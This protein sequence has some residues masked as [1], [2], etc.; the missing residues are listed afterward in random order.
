MI[1]DSPTALYNSILPRADTDVGNVT[2]TI[3]SN[4][5]P[6]PATNSTPLSRGQSVRPLPPRIYDHQTR[7]T[8]FGELVFSVSSGTQSMAPMSTKAFEVGQILDF[9]EPEPLETI[10]VLNV[11]DTVDL[12]QNT[13]VLDFAAAGLTTDEASELQTSAA[14]Q[15]ATKINE[16]N[17]IKTQISDNN[18]A[19]QDNQRLLNEIQKLI[20]ASTVVFGSDTTIP[21]K[22]VVRQ[23]ELQL[24]R[25]NLIN[26]T[27]VLTTEAQT[28]YAE[29]LELKE[30][31]R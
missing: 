23:Q 31:V 14:E 11:P 2:F 30:V 7:R 25:T 1:I 19:I 15:I 17:A 24:E 3:S 4:D 28:K 26:G 9:D 16:L 18:T 22:L 21:D 8:T 5:P 12:Q 29:I 10:A 6:R 27:N 20:N 13:N